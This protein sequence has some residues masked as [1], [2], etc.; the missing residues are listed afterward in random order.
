MR[1]KYIIVFIA[2]LSSCKPPVTVEE[3]ISQD[4][5]SDIVMEVDTSKNGNSPNSFN[6][7]IELAP[8]LIGSIDSLSRGLNRSLSKMEDLDGK[9]LFLQLLVDENGGTS[10]FEIIKP[11]INQQYSDSIIARLQGLRFQPGTV[12]GKPVKARMILPLNF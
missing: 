1:L 12:N 2:L 8:K 10:D 11:K 7:P 3:Q 5:F 9:V 4:D 6:H